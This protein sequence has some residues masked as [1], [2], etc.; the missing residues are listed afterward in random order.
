[1]YKREKDIF[2]NEPQEPRYLFV[3][4]SNSTWVISSSIAEQ[5]TIEAFVK[6]CKAT[7]RP[8]SDVAGMCE[9]MG[10][11]GWRYK[12]AEGRWQE[13]GIGVTCSFSRK[14]R[15]SGDGEGEDWLEG[16]ISVSAS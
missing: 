13:G 14:R 16:D 11:T 7:N 1:M 6:S 12:N 2:A 5:N 10:I 3:P 8:D 9:K 4:E 15:E